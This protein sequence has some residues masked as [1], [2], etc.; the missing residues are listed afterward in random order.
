ML[1]TVCYK[2]VMCMQYHVYFS[3]SLVHLI[4]Q[5]MLVYFTVILSGTS[6]N[7]DFRGFLIQ[8]RTSG[9]S[10]NAGTFVD[11]GDD[12]QIRC[13]HNVRMHPNMYIRPSNSFSIHVV[14]M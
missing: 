3:I 1:H 6:S 2:V 14:C 13:N 9:G 4:K 8:S 11:N 12:Q 5:C 7:V 10:T